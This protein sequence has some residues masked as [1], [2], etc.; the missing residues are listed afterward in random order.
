VGFCFARDTVVMFSKINT[1]CEWDTQAEW[2]N[3]G[4]SRGASRN[5]DGVMAVYQ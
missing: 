4:Y 5:E 2:N 3:R 1:W